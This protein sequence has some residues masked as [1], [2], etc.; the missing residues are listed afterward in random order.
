MDQIIRLPSQLGALVRS[1]RLERNLTQ[2][3][4]ANLIGKQQKTISAIENGSEGTKLDTLLSVIAILDLDLQ[5]VSR[6]KDGKD[7]T[8]VF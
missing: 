1:A 3:Q 6:R 7:I 2:Q 8:D 4:L 5:V